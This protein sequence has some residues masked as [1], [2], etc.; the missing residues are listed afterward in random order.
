M[1]QNQTNTPETQT[2]T[3]QLPRKIG[4]S[5][6]QKCATDKTYTGG[7]GKTGPNTLSIERYNELWVAFQSDQ[8]MRAVARVTRVSYQTVRKYV[9]DGD[10]KRG[11]LP[12]RERLKGVQAE[13]QV[14]E[15]IS[16]ADEIHTGLAI[17][18]KLIKYIEAQLG[19]ELDRLAF[20]DDGSVVGQYVYDD[21]GKRQCDPNGIP[22]VVP[23]SKLTNDPIGAFN[24]IQ[25]LRLHLLGEPDLVTTEDEYTRFTE[26]ELRMLI[27]TGRKPVRLA[28]RAIHSKAA[29]KD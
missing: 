7:N 9:Q 19:F 27:Q 26:E 29:T 15:R 12:L 6:K 22:K 3:V 18:D 13:V 8:S 25:R 11:L 14:V 28:G 16:M 17:T 4:L 23:I 24:S 21:A 20:A 1:V 10:P 2:N 5:N